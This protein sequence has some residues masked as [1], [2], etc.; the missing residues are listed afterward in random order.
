MHELT[1][2]DSLTDLALACE[3]GVCFLNHQNPTGDPVVVE[4]L[5]QAEYTQVVCSELINAEETATAITMFAINRQGELYFI[6]GSRDWNNGEISLK[7]SGLP[8]RTDVA[9]ISCQYNAKLDSSEL[10]YASTDNDVIKHLLR[11]PE[12]TCWS[13]NIIPF[14]APKS[15]TTYQ[16]FT[17]TI[18]VRSTDGRI[19][20]GFPVGISAPSTIALVNDHSYALSAQE[21]QIKTN[22]RGQIVLVTPAMNSLMAPSYTVKVSNAGVSHSATFHGGQR[23]STILSRIRDEDDLIGAKSSAGKRIFSPSDISRRPEEFKECAQ[24]LG[25]LPDMLKAVGD[26]SKAGVSSL[27]VQD[28]QLSRGMQVGGTENVSIQS[29]IVKDM[30]GFLGDAIE[31]LKN[32]AKSTFK[33]VFKVLTTGVKLVLKIAGKVLSFVFKTVGPLLKTIGTFL[34]EKLGLD[35]GKLFQWLG[36][37]FDTEKTKTNQEVRNFSSPFGQH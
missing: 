25:Q 12:T 32:A 31:W 30:T 26:N 17:T 19:L 4:N 6:E 10:I 1:L 24:F 3:R 9:R 33:A 28:I 18:S 13:E 2:V 35:S 11:D 8:I 29:D 27:G 23:V 37:T 21:T 5:P 7:S 14:A 34:K 36:L 16:S 20:S 22:D 15:F